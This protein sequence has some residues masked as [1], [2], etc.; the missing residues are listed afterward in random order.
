[1]KMSPLEQLKTELTAKF[2]PWDSYPSGVEIPVTHKFMLG[3]DYPRFVGNLYKILLGIKGSTITRFEDVP[4][5]QV[6]FRVT[7]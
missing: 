7:V 4:A 2:I 1:M 5:E 6:V 3:Q